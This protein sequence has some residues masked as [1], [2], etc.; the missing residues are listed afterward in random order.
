MANFWT[1]PSDKTIATIEERVT[2]RLSLP[3]NGRYLPLATSGM[4]VTVI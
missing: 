2:V 1:I 3:V 4:T